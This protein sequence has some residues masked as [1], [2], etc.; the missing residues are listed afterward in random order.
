M[1]LPNRSCTTMTKVQKRKT[2]KSEK[3]KG[4]EP[5]RIVASSTPTRWH[6]ERQR[7]GHHRN[8][9]KRRVQSSGVWPSVTRSK[10]C[11]RTLSMTGSDA[12]I[13]TWQSMKQRRSGRIRSSNSTRRRSSSSN[14]N[15]L[16]DEKGIWM[17]DRTTTTVL[18]MMI[19][20]CQYCVSTCCLH[21]HLSLCH[22]SSAPFCIV[23][24]CPLLPN[25]G[26]L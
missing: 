18:V 24:C 22:F 25:H 26:E 12:E 23:L 4:K 15:V 11:A 19:I 21:V 7:T 6:S 3:T 8:V 2:Q 5:N 16:Q 14:N 13:S 10:S 20:K 9:P 1:P 17:G